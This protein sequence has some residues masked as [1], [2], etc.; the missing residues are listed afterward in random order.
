MEDNGE[1]NR[2]NNRTDKQDGASED[3]GRSVQNTG[4]NT[5][6][7]GAAP[8]GRQAAPPT[9][10]PPA[11][12]ES[13]RWNYDDYNRYDY[14]T[15]QRKTRRTG[16]KVLVAGTIL[17]GVFAMFLLSFAS[18]GVYR[19]F[20]SDG[21]ASSSLTGESNSK[22]TQELTID[23]TPS[24][25]DTQTA[26]G[27][28]S[29]EQ[30]SKKVKPSVVGVVTYESLDTMSGSTQGSGIIMSADGYIITNAHVVDTSASLIKVILD[31][32][33][34]YE[35]QIVGMD[36]R[37]DLAVLKID[38]KNLT[39]ATFGNSEQLQVGQSVLA[40]GN[41][42]GMEL[43]GSVTMGIVSAV[44]RKVV[45]ELGYTM[46]TVQTDAAI[47]PGNSGGALVNLYGQVIGI[48]SLKIAATEYEGIGFAIPINDA[49]P[50]IDK[51]IQ[52]GRVPNRVKLGVSLQEIGEVA[53]KSYNVPEGLLIA[54]ISAD[55][56]LASKG[57]V[58]GDIITAVDGTTVTTVSELMAILDSHSPGD[59]V[60]VTLY[61]R[62]KQDQGSTINVTIA[63]QE[64]K[65]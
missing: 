59:T 8:T 11:A 65:S 52:Y 24:G 16:R 58:T 48:N 23:S 4:W 34:E 39:Y 10:P 61:R 6:S 28:L 18:Y 31:N 62:S 17:A 35:A 3:L 45:S 44:N 37:T 60:T 42:G 63:L 9:P 32:E 19:A 38:A 7:Y 46:N 21:S 25:S 36:T 51:L 14:G 2:E 22:K 56:N 33:D 55:S 1:N 53:A 57:V 26:E 27:K 5:V 29:S 49:K 13:Y 30:V 15:K 12:S 50:I 20:F 40:I 47:N 64:D 43:A 54:R 41:P